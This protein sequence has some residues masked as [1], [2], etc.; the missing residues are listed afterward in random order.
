MSA[1][2]YLAATRERRKPESVNVHVSC[3]EHEYII[4]RFGDEYC[5]HCGH[6]LHVGDFDAW[7][8]EQQV[9]YASCCPGADD[10]DCICYIDQ[11]DDHTAQYD[12]DYADEIRDALLGHP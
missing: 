11:Y 4:N 8:A 3:S 5:R 10:D 12:N 6:V 9:G 7:Q 2:S 1:T